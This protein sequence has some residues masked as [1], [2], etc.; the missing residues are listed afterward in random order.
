MA[1]SSPTLSIENAWNSVALEERLE[2]IAR[3]HAVGLASGLGALVMLASVAY[4]FD[5]PLAFF[6]S[7]AI[8]VALMPIFSSRYWRKHKPTT[9]LQY[10]AVRSVA[11][12]YALGFN[13]RELDIVLIF[14]GR[15]KEIFESAE[16][17]ELILQNRQHDYDQMPDEDTRVW[18]SLFRGGVVILSEYNGGAKLESVTVLNEETLCRPAK[19][20]E[21]GSKHA[22]V[23]RGA[24]DGRSRL[25]LIDSKYVGALYVFKQRLTKLHKEYVEFKKQVEKLRAEGKYTKGR[26]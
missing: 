24:G 7:L 15:M 25:L 11:R 2:L 3:S 21:G 19:P 1:N 13:I 10:L 18:V 14:R 23:I 26:R 5:E 6:G 22:T 17:R 20:E 4:G 16:E 9:I 12:R 8:S